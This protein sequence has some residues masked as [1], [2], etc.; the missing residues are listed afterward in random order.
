[1]DDSTG[2]RRRQDVMTSP[3]V[4]RRFSE[5]EWQE[6][7][8]ANVDGGGTDERGVPRR[9]WLCHGEVGMHVQRVHMPPGNVVRPH[10]HNRDELMLVLE[11]SLELDGFGSFGVGDAVVI[12]ANEPYGFV[13]GPDGLEFLIIRTGQANLTRH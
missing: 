11:G 4:A 12:S 9:A 10:S 3:I 1:M 2:G 13:V 7:R 6:G 5:L 8:P